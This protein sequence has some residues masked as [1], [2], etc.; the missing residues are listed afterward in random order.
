MYVTTDTSKPYGL[1]IN[2]CDAQSILSDLWRQ[3]WRPDHLM[4]Q[5]IVAT[6]T[7]TDIETLSRSETNSTQTLW[8]VICTYPDRASIRHGRN[9]RF[10]QLMPYNRNSVNIIVNFTQN[11]SAHA[12]RSTK[13]SPSPGVRYPI[14]HSNEWY[15]GHFA[16][17][18]DRTLTTAI[19]KGLHI[20]SCTQLVFY[21]F[22]KHV[23]ISAVFQVLA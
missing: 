15:I 5:G 16:C 12:C 11:T 22:L 9:V 3:P 18:S 2:W 19:H 1:T 6:I 4:C 21:L 23:Q 17:S 13:I 10:G 14:F 20:C 7:N 8:H